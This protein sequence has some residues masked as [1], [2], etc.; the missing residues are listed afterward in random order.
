MLEMQLWGAEWDKVIAANPTWSIL[1]GGI[2][3]RWNTSS[4]NAASY[5]KL[6]KDGIKAEVASG[7]SSNNNWFRG[8]EMMARM[9]MLEGSKYHNDLD[10]LKRVVYGAFHPICTRMHIPKQLVD[11]YLDHPKKKDDTHTHTLNTHT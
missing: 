1:T 5:S 3:P 7:E 9:Y 10:V 6:T 11:R 8:L 2:W 4:H